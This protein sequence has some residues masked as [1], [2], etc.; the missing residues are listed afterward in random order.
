MIVIEI[1]W[2]GRV[3]KEIDAIINIIVNPK[4]SVDEDINFHIEQDTH[5]SSKI[6]NESDYNFHLYL[7]TIYWTTKP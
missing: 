7:Q 2:A 3:C 5:M 4:W 6:H 1:A